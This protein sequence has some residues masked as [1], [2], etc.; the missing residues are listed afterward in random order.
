MCHDCSSAL[1]L[2]VQRNSFECAFV[3]QEDEDMLE[4]FENACAEFQA[5]CNDFENVIGQPPTVEAKKHMRDV[6]VAIVTIA[7]QWVLS[8]LRKS[9]RTSKSKFILIREDV[10][11]MWTTRIKKH[12]MYN[13]VRTER[14]ELSFPTSPTARDFQIFASVLLM[15]Y[16]GPSMETAG[17]SAST[18]QFSDREIPHFPSNSPV[19][20]RETF[21]RWQ[22]TDACSDLIIASV[23]QLFASLLFATSKTPVECTKV[24]LEKFFR[25]IGELLRYRC[26]KQVTYESGIETCDHAFSRRWVEMLRLSETAWPSIAARPL[27]I[28]AYRKLASMLQCE[29]VGTLDQAKEEPVVVKDGSPKSVFHTVAWSGSRD[30][31]YASYLHM[32]MLLQ[33]NQPTYSKLRQAVRQGLSYEDIEK[34]YPAV[35]PDVLSALL[36]DVTTAGMLDTLVEAFLDEEAL[37]AMANQNDPE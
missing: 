10:S 8:K 11:S 14:K 12:F 29:Y 26:W 31:V 4:W 1:D 18:F 32:Y 3:E 30:I 21:W 6:A 28:E 35:L 5:Q 34:Q 20:E 36:K 25:V 27:R 22:S 24:V 2:F 13:H 16:E 7:R 19:F 15:K 9:T 17:S 37:S 33:R 23:E